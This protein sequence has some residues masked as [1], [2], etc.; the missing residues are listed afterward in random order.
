MSKTRPTTHERVM[1]KEDFIISKTDTKGK[2]T[3]CN[4]IFMDMSM[5]SEEELLGKAHSIVRHPDMPKVIF[6]LLWEKVTSGKEI[7]AYVKNLSKDGSF[8]WV[9]AN[10]TPSYDNSHKIIGYYSVRIKPNEEALAVIKPL[11]QKL[12]SLESSGGIKSSQE[13]LTNLLNEKGVS[14]DEFIITLQAS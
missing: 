5:M 12:L 14:Y 4:E 11:Y 9:L 2:I 6:K 7:F 3:Y 1:N 13:Y 8:Y 10:V